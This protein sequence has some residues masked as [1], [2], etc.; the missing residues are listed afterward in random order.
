VKIHIIRSNSLN[1]K[2]KYATTTALS[3][4]T[5][6]MDKFGK[7]IP[8][9]TERA[10][11]SSNSSPVRPN[12]FRQKPSLTEKNLRDLIKEYY[13]VSMSHKLPVAGYERYL[14]K[15]AKEI[16]AKLEEQK[17]LLER[18]KRTPDTGDGSVQMQKAILEQL[19][20]ANL[21]HLA[22]ELEKVKKELDLLYYRTSLYLGRM[23]QKLDRLSK[24]LGKSKSEI[25]REALEEYMQKYG[26]L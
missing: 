15:K 12:E 14:L 13:G 19:V 8:S 9:L 3:N 23:G 24:Y 4:Q 10:R 1:E 26:W 18:L 20:S 7:V 22:E 6:E 25:V 21:D 2:L 5:A 17:K 16:K 11:K